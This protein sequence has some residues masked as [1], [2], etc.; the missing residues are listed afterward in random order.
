MTKI[1]PS[2]AYFQQFY[3]PCVF[4]SFSHASFENVLC[5]SLT[6]LGNYDRVQELVKIDKKNV[7]GTALIRASE[8][9]KCLIKSFQ[10]LHKILEYGIDKFKFLISNGANVSL[11]DYMGQTPLHAGSFYENNI[12]FSS[13]LLSIKH[14]TRKY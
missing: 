4:Y 8:A 6:I 3:F 2:N 13:L 12:N 10:L 7:G 14:N 9:G 5:I 11:P 1:L